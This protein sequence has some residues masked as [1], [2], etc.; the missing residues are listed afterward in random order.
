M[1]NT[2]GYKI[3]RYFFLGIILL[4]GLLLLL[5][6]MEFFTA[7]L[8]AVMFYVLCKK[9]MERLIKRKWKK[10]SAATV[11]ILFTF[12]IIMLPVI[13]LA[14]M[15]Y[16]KI[17]TIAQSPSS[18]LEPFQHFAA[19]VNQR[20]HIDINKGNYIG[21]LQK[22]AT[23]LITTVINSGF[24]FFSTIIMMYFFLYFMLIKTNTMEAAIILYLPFKRDK[25]QLFGNE[26]ISQTFSNAVGV[27]LIAVVHGVLAFIAYWIAGLKEPGFWG[28]ITGFA[29]VIPLVGTA[30]VWIPVAVY[31]L[32]TG[33][34]WQG[35]F[36]L[37][38]GTIVIGLS[39]NVIRF[40]LAK[41]MADVHPIVTVLGVIIGLKYFGLTGLIFGP[42]IISY[43]LLLLKIYYAEYRKQPEAGKKRT[44]LPSYLQSTFAPAAKN[45][46][47]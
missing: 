35:F 2:Q 13:L 5:S 22:Y 4:L 12:F 8:G 21:D 23:S 32:A 6:L 38:W 31:L 9:N 14:T 46:K 33:N 24:N 17:I 27:P 26:L 37:G 10:S 36:V 16:D 29:S 39:D 11:I 41:K 42:L 45:K 1:Q 19:I 43:F 44:I 28:V 47:K 34:S 7:F 15:L 40:L 18:V 20:F 3:N 25:I 30:I